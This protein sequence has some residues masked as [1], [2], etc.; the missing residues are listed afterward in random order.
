MGKESGKDIY[1][2]I[3]LFIYLF[4]KKYLNHFAIYLKLTHYKSAILQ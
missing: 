1:I 3:Y 2:Y 4:W